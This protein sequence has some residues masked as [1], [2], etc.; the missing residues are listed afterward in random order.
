MVSLSYPFI[1]KI[2]ACFA[3]D[4]HI[5]LFL[6][7]YACFTGSSVKRA[8]LGCRASKDF[9]RPGTNTLTFSLQTSI[10]VGLLYK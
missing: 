1:L 6:Q 7:T 2:Y 3:N 8:I 10:K 5:Y 4:F 9:L